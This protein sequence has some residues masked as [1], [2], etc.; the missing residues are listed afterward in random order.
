MA[1]K[2]PHVAKV[3][4][5]PDSVLRVAVMDFDSF[6]RASDDLVGATEI[7]LEDRLFSPRWASQMAARPPVEWRSLF[8]ERSHHPQGVLELWVETWGAQD[9]APGA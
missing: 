1:S 5:E 3:H 9:A 6:G 2:Q 4:Q 7:D 8:S